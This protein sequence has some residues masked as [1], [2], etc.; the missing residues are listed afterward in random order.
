[1]KKPESNLNGGESVKS[2]SSATDPANSG[3][4]PATMTVDQIFKENSPDPVPAESSVIA[5]AP[6]ASRGT[7]G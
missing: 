6:K 3:G 5:I 2:P 4:M 7:G 1:M